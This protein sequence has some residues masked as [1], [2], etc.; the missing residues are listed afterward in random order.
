MAV[1]ASWTLQQY[2]YYN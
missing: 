1:F 2:L